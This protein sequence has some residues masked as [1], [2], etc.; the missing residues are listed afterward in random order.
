MFC[1][2]VVQAAH[3][4]ALLLEYGT[5]SAP[6]FI[7]IDGGPATIY[8]RHLRQVL[9]EVHSK[10]RTL[11]LAILSHVDNDHVIGMLDYFAELATD[12]PDLPRPAALWHNA[13]GDAIDP[14]RD[15]TPR[16]EALLTVNRAAAMPSAAAAVNG[17]G[18][19]QTLRLRAR[20]AEVPVNPD[21]LGGLVTV[22]DMR[23][24]MRFANLSLRVVGP[25]RANLAALRDEWQ[26][27]LERHERAVRSDDVMI[28]ANSD[29]SIPNLSSLMLLA[30]ADGRTLLLTG[31]G[32]SD[33]LLQG[34]GEAGLLAGD[35]TLHVDVLKLPHHGSDRN[36]TRRFFRRITADTYVASA[37]GRDGNPDVAT[38]IWIVEAAHEQGRPIALVVTNP[39]PSVTKLTEEYPPDEYGYTLEV[40]PDTEHAVRV[41]LAD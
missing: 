17:I 11:D 5:A 15:I 9:C 20:M 12:P 26:H 1:L 30:E 31:D 19:G 37:N 34:L 28:L 6:R 38:L 23:D 33:H 21:V 7:L 18:E 10:V 22:E 3:G 13:F 36:V 25:T 27:W 39:T 35:G 24:E 14:D 2:H 40:L 16:L 29:R 32:R 4:D 8:D 41:D